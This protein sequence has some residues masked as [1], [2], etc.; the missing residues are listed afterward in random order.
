MTGKSSQTPKERTLPTGQV[1]TPS[2]DM[3]ADLSA[4]ALPAGRQV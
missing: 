4:K 3:P 2:G 1:S